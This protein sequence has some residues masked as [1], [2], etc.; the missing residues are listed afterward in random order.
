MKKLKLKSFLKKFREQEL[1]VRIQL[2]PIKK[3][4]DE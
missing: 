4:N 3:N 2:Q 1:N